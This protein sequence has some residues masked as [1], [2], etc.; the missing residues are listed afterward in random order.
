MHTAY[1][2]I[3]SNLGE[4]ESTIR[5][6]LELAADPGTRRRGGLPSA[7]D[8]VGVVDQP[9]F[10]NAAIRLA[11]DLGPRPLLERL[12]AE[13]LDVSVPASAT[14]RGRSTWTSCSTAT[15]SWTNRASAS[16]T[17]GWQ[18]G[19]SCSSLSRSSIPVSSSLAW[20]RFRPCSRG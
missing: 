18:S 17:R 3:G 10:L 13:Q 9:R 15:R 1:I 16:R 7:T 6:A 19:A 12:L 14:G 2:G 8:P 20:G 5:D 4:R 11:T